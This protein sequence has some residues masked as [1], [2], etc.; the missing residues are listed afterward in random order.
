MWGGVH[1][2]YRSPCNNAPRKGGG[3][4]ASQKFWDPAYSDQI[5]QCWKQDQYFQT[6]AKTKTRCTRPRSRPRPKLQDQDQDRHWSETG[7]VI[8]PRSQTTTLKLGT[9]THVGKGCFSKGPQG[10][11]AQRPSHFFLL[12]LLAK[13]KVCSVCSDQLNV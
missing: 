4:R 13:I 3:V 1:F 12:S 8:R 11:W 6:K 7:L 9:V 5:R 10:Y 2:R